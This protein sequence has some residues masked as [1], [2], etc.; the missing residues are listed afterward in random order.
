M[1]E[2]GFLLGALRGLIRR[3]PVARGR[4]HKELAQTIGP[5]LD[6]VER[7][8]TFRAGQ[9]RFGR[10]M[11]SVSGKDR[12]REAH[13]H[14]GIVLGQQALGV[15]LDDLQR[16]GAALDVD[17]A[18]IAGHLRT[19]Q[20]TVADTR[21]AV[22]ATA[23]GLA[24]LAAETELLAD[25]LAACET[26]LDEL[27]TRLDRQAA[28]LT[29]LEC[30]ELGLN[31][32]DVAVSRWA[33]GETYTGLPFVGSI[34]LLATEI[35]AGPCGQYELLREAG[36]G[37]S[38]D[39]GAPARYFRRQL[40]RRVTERARPD[41]WT[42]PR[43]TVELLMSAGDVDRTDADVVAEILG[44]RLHPALATPH[45]AFATALARVLDIAAQRQVTTADAQDAIDR[46]RAECGPMPVRLDGAEFVAHA[47]GAVCRAELRG[48]RRLTTG[49]I[50][51][52]MGN[53]A[54]GAAR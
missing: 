12:A 5:P 33:D 15:R 31:G 13:I 10:L 24:E 40:V 6:Q 32:L 41:L 18:R 9:S 25:L 22:H 16:R 54:N 30:H 4:A 1:R 28:R 21:R 45:G 51:N 34:V 37:P 50:A 48:R 43:S 47:V 42:T 20:L 38:A 39:D 49:P 3:I 7:L 53:N 2:D 8:V 44:A 14:R 46:A 19:V 29:R 35:A 26:R 52:L 23:T 36:D 17:V 11:S 27:D